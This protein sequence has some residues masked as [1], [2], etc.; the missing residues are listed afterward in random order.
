MDL[1]T[2]PTFGATVA[3]EVAG[4]SATNQPTAK[5]TMPYG[6]VVGWAGSPYDG[7][8]T[9]PAGAYPATSEPVHYSPTAGFYQTTSGFM[10]WVPAAGYYYYGLPTQYYLPRQSAAAPEWIHAYSAPEPDRAVTASR[11]TTAPDIIQTEL[12]WRPRAWGDTG[13]YTA[14]LRGQMRLQKAAERSSV[15]VDRDCLRCHRR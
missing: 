1:S 15:V 13:S 10:I 2:V 7:R 3:F 11:S 8:V 9:I 6:P 4:L 12:F 5:F 14:W